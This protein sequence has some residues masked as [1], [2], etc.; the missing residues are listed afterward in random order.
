MFVMR[1]V[2]SL[3][4]LSVHLFFFLLAAISLFV[5]SNFRKLRCWL[6]K[7]ATVLVPHQLGSFITN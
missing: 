4:S 3:L 6:G 7:L 1:I 2:K 5:K